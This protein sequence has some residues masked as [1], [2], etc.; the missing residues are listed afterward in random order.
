MSITVSQDLL[1]SSATPSVLSGRPVRA[2]GDA[3]DSPASKTNQATPQGE[4]IKAPAAVLAML[5]AQNVQSSKTVYDEPGQRQ[6]KAV[7]AYQDVLQQDK[8]EQLQQMF[9]IDLY[10]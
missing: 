3:T 5:D 10:A 7:S 6:Q 2:T 4:G 9:A 1:R 8:K